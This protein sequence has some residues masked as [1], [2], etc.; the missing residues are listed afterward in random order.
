MAAIFLLFIAFGCGSKP[1][2]PADAEPTKI[3][4]PVECATIEIGPL[5]EVA[6]LNATASFLQKS[7]VSATANGFLSGPEIRLGQFVRAGD[8]L[9]TL[10]NKEAASLGNL[11][12]AVDTSF[13]LKKSLEIRANKSG[14]I[15]Q[16]DHQ[17]GD[18]VQDGEQLATISEAS[19]FAFVLDLPFELRRF[20][21]QNRSVELVLPDQTRLRAT[22]ESAMPMVDP[23]HFRSYTNFPST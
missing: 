1:V 8:V 14:F 22:V 9:F 23:G 19:S 17:A 10:K 7:K 3:G 5:R 15:A 6:E 16:L 11:I 4:T 2:E 13:H 12:D 18:Y 20:L 21:P